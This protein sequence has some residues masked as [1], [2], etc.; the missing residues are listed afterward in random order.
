MWLGFIT[1]STLWPPIL[2]V[3][4][5]LS[6]LFTHCI[7]VSYSFSKY[8]IVY[9]SPLSNT[10]SGCTPSISVSL[11]YISPELSQSSNSKFPSLIGPAPDS[12][13]IYYPSMIGC[14]SL[15]IKFYW[16]TK[17]FSNLFYNIQVVFS[18]GDRLQITNNGVLLKI[19]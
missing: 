6:T 1:K 9:K 16:I 18:S 13:F 11:P 17:Y 19:S 8:S 12:I 14:R 4:I 7:L 5:S 10:L 2:P 3:Y 15:L